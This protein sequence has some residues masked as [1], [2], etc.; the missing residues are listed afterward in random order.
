MLRAMWLVPLAAS[1]TAGVFA[2]L[3]ARRYRA[4]RRPAELLW[5]LALLMYAVASFTLF[6]GVLGTWNGTEYRLY[7]LFG[8]VLN[9]P[10]LAVGEV[11][12]LVKDRRVTLPVLV[13]LLFTTAFAIARIRTAT[14]DVTALAADLPQGKEVWAGDP[15]ALD[16]ARFYAF[17]TYFL[18]L[19][20]TLWSAWRMRGNSSLRDRFLGLLAIAIGATIVAAG[21][22]FALTGNVVGFSI[23]LTAG[24][25]VM[26]WGFVRS[27][28]P[29][30]ASSG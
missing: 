25:A 4:R 2:G 30:S 9:V 21:S 15:L 12:L 8:A 13:L 14:L 5:A 16:L 6:L 1:I 7:W 22:A 29:V 3:L 19:G 20:G 26:F 17:P 10:Y 28:R 24:I 18:L 11:L 27:S 23:T